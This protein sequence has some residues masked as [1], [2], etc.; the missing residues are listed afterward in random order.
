MR[1]YELSV[2]P[3]D[4]RLESGIDKA[5]AETETSL[6]QF[7]QLLQISEK[8]DA[9]SVEA[10][11]Y[12]QSVEQQLGKTLLPKQTDNVKLELEVRLACCD[13]TLPRSNSPLMAIF[14]Y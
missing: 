8:F 5:A 1:L 9:T 14:V 2:A 3:I 11:S 13:I 12:L 4:C 10:E 6:D 7:Q